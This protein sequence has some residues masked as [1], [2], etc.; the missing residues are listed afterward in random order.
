MDCGVGFSTINECIGQG[1]TDCRKNEQVANNVF[2]RSK[3]AHHD[4]WDSSGKLSHRNNDWQNN[5]YFPDGSNLFCYGLCA[6]GR[7]PCRNCTNFD[8]F[9]LDEPHLTHSM[10]KQPQFVNA[11]QIPAGLRPQPRSPLLGS[12][13]DVGLDHDWAGEKL[14]TGTMPSIGIF[15]APATVVPVKLRVPLKLDDSACGARSI[16]ISLLTLGIVASCSSSLPA[17]NN[18]KPFHTLHSDRLPCLQYSTTIGPNA[19]PSSVKPGGICPCYHSSNAFGAVI[20]DHLRT[21]NF[22]DYDPSKCITSVDRVAEA[23]SPLP[24][25]QRAVSWLALYRPQMINGERQLSSLVAM[26]DKDSENNTLPWADEWQKAVRQ[27]LNAWFALYKSAD[28]PAIDM[29]FYDLESLSFGFGHSFAFAPGHRTNFSAIF[30]PWQADPRWPALLA[31]LN[32]AGQ[33]F[34][35]NFTNMT[36]AAETACCRSDICYPG[37]DTNDFHQYVWN[38][39]MSQRVAQ[40]MNATLYSSIT[41]HFPNI[42]TSNYDQARYSSEPQYW[43]GHLNSYVRPP[44]GTG[45]HVGTHSSQ[46]F[47]AGE[48]STE[49]LSITSPFSTVNRTAS[50]FGRLLVATR[51]IR[52]IARQGTPVMPWLEPRDGTWYKSGRGLLYGSDL[53]QEMLLHMAL[54]G[55]RRFLWWRNSHNFPLTL[56]I[57][58]ANCVLAEADVMVGDH[59][60]KPLSWDTAVSLE[61]GFVL[62]S[63]R[64]GNGTI[65]HRFT[66]S[67]EQ[68][69]PKF[70]ELGVEPASFLVAGHVVTPV[71]RGRLVA[72]SEASCSPGGY[73]IVEGVEDAV[74]VKLRVPLKLD[75]SACGG[76]FLGLI[77]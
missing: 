30:G 20:V 33:P 36:A 2:L 65:V 56:G 18:A 74:P 70:A 58:L 75:D 66:P 47:Y 73:W 63:V 52:S 9:Q 1:G 34:G 8:G 12:G 10:V 21:C 26:W 57:E 24:A 22:S 11:A 77:A 55:V 42:Q 62:S 13:A 6:N 37:C 53:Y 72:A 48:A 23:L 35:V 43:A 46:S 4:G 54:A 68:P 39:V 5:L 49:V 14:P 40:M 7:L 44:I 59:L 51:E 76:C 61:A 19:C 67:D 38:F 28:R 25:G 41:P 16:G 71:A 3:S 60:R 69:R 17:G 64:L 50:A 45:C 32:A 31:E 27:R 29:V 15:Q